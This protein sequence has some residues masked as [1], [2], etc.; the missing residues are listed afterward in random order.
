MGRFH[1]NIAC[2]LALATLFCMPIVHAQSVP[3]TPVEARAES[4]AAAGTL[5]GVVRD[6]HNLPIVGAT[7]SLQPEDT[8]IQILT[9]H[10]DSAGAYVFFAVRPGTYTLRAEMTGYGNPPSNCLNIGQKESRKVDLTLDAAKPNT[11]N[12]PSL[13]P[14]EFFDEPHFTVAGV[15]DTSNFGGHGG[16]TIARNREVLAQATASLSQQSLDDATLNSSRPAME[17]SL[18][19]V[20]AQLAVQGK[21]REEIAELHHLLAETDERLGNSLE[22]VQEYRLAAELNP[23]ERNLFDWGAELLLHRADEPA[24]EVFTKGNLAFPRSVRMLAGLGAAW[25][26]DGSYEKAA[27][28]LSEASDLNPDDPNPYLFMGEMQALNSTPSPTIE[29]HLARFCALQ[30]KNS[31]ANYYYA[32][33]L[34]KHRNSLG[35]AEDIDRVK[36]LLLTAVRLDPKLGVAYLELGIVYSQQKD[37]PKAISALQHAIEADPKLDNAHYRLAQV[38]RLAGETSKAQTELQLYEQ[39]SKQNAEEIGRQ[40]HALQQ[41]VYELRDRTPGLQPQ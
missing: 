28:H 40:R 34:Q 22:A 12:N 29:E 16:D 8:Q 13:T 39:I 31:W 6:A 33:S 24:I 14:P 2:I 32:A 3:A 11:L 4:E 26:S 1:I 18:Q 38:Y 27:Q 17:K 10:T 7:V 15:A 30:P 37:F 41:F 5:H 21:S 9:A 35:N 36:S 19:D 23:S 25:Y 20:R